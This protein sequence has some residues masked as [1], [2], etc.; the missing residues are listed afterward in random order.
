MDFMKKKWVMTVIIIGCFAVSGVIYYHNNKTIDVFSSMEGKTMWMLCCNSK[1]R[2]S[3]EIPQKDYFEF[4]KENSNPASLGAAPMICEKCKEKSAFAAEKCPECGNVFL[5][6][7]ITGD[8]A[9]RCP[10]C[11]YSQT[12]ESRKKGQ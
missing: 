5:P 6:N 11:K 10:E 4:Q 9:D 8:F 2:A 12:Q 1:C 3:F 7:S